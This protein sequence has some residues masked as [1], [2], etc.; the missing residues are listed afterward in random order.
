MH[1]VVISGVLILAGGLMAWEANRNWLSPVV[2]TVGVFLFFYVGGL[3]Y[4]FTQGH[5]STPLYVA[6]GTFFYGLGAILMASFNGFRPV[7][8]R[9][10]FSVAP[11]VNIFPIRKAFFLSL[12]IVSLFSIAA[13][14]VYFYHV[15][16]PLLTEWSSLVRTKAIPGKGV[17]LRILWTFLPL[18]TLIVFLYNKSHKSR[19]SAVLMWGLF[20]F[21]AL[22]LILYG[23]RGAA[24]V[25]IVPFIFIMGVLYR[26]RVIGKAIT[27][28][29]IFLLAGFVFQ[30]T[31]FGYRDLPFV[32]AAA[33][34]GGRLTTQQVEALDYLVYDVIPE[35]GF[36][37]GK[38]HVIGLRGF[39]GLFRIIP[40]EPPFGEIL[41][42]MKAGGQVATSFT[43]VTTTFGD[44]YADFGAIGIATGMLLYGIITQFLYIRTLRR[45][46][47]YFRLGLICFLQYMILGVHIGGEVF[48][49]LVSRGVSIVIFVLL[50]TFLYALLSLPIGRITI[51]LPSRVS[52]EQFRL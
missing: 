27:L 15:G 22:F 19:S 9:Q 36:Y 16:I 4:F 6:L 25:Y 26:K 48:A 40:Y 52:R 24:V 17:Y 35:R 32:D 43:L 46:K 14:A 45:C 1:V 42:R 8:E 12:W 47:N 23:S 38:L 33:T 28:V 37:L 7:S 10:A 44:L 49:A 50:L 31:Y 51:L 2:L 5:A 3:V 11:F 34:L 20:A 13:G 29:M 39:L 30:Y 21:S 18:E 41:F